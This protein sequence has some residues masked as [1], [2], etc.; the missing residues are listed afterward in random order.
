MLNV[1][2]AGLP[3]TEIETLVAERCAALGSVYSVS[4][5]RPH[6]QDEFPFALVAMSSPAE[7]EALAQRIGDFMFGHAVLV[8]LAQQP[9]RV[10]GSR[11]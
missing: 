5:H 8:K 4:V 2:L 10:S 1:D 9:G 3:D 6:G 11:S 7:M